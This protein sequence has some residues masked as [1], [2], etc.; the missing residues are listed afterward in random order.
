V[1]AYIYIE[2]GG[3]SKELRT[4]C[5]EGFSKLLQSA[6]FE[7]RMPRLVAC[8]GRTAAYEDFVTKHST[9]THPYVALWI[10]SEE[11][12]TDI[13]GAWAHLT[14][15]TTVA[16]WDRPDGATNEQVLFMTTCMETW[17]TADRSTLRLH[18]GPKLQPSA[19]PPVQNLEQRNRH[20]VQDRLT[21]ATRNCSNA[22]SKGKRSFEILGKL[23]P[24]LLARSLPSFVRVLRILNE[25]LVQ[26]R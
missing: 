12:M 15:V 8:G 20:D 6:G 19:L 7:G 18:Y 14:N 9:T 4:R 17:I 22:Y 23:T 2:G 21:H 5:R 3:D 13:E 10:D 16:R 26:G 25:K 24:E 1:S 11:P